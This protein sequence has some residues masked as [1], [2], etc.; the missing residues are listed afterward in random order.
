MFVLQIPWLLGSN[1]P[2]EEDDNSIQHVKLAASCTH[3]SFNWSCKTKL[4]T[5]T[6]LGCC[7][8]GQ[9]DCCCCQPRCQACLKCGVVRCG[10]QTT[11]GHLNP[12]VDL[13]S[14][15][16]VILTLNLSH[17]LWSFWLK[18]LDV[19][20]D[21]SDTFLSLLFCKHSIL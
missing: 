15:V 7:Q 3:N 5:F 8:L 17:V 13:V 19:S 4:F 2:G 1:Q 10:G 18:L 9:A 12:V 16:N 14:F 21:L 20:G 6:F 11:T